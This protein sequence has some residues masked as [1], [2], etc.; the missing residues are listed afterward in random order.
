MQTVVQIQT[1]GVNPIPPSA[2]QQQQQQQ[3]SATPHPQQQQQQQQQQQRTRT[4]NPRTPKQYSQ[5]QLTYL[6]GHLSEFERRSAGAIR[7]DAKKFAL[8]RANDFI[9]Q[10]GLPIEF[11]G[12]EEG[13]A[14]FKEVRSYVPALSYN[15]ISNA[16]VTKCFIFIYLSFLANI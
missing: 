13:E 7:G 16:F 2:T 14:R 8:E 1:P 4:Q 6:R 5:E 3:S 10:F 12:I 11:A 9:H 15:V